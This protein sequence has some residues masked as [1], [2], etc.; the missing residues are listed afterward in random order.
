MQR[1]EGPATPSKGI[2][3]TTAGVSLVPISYR[4]EVLASPSLPMMQLPITLYDLRFTFPPPC[5]TV[6][7][8]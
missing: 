6:P 5:V 4:K 8:R 3:P 7:R 1:Q 2:L